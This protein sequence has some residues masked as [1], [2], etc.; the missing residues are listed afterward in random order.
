MNSSNPLRN[1]PRK[2]VVIFLLAV[3]FT[4]VAMGI[5]NDIVAMGRMPTLR[6]GLALMLSGA[7]AV[8]DAVAGVT[9]RSRI[10]KAF[11]PLFATQIAIMSFLANKYP[12]TPQLRQMDATETSRL[13][14]RLNFAGV[15]TIITVCL[16]YA[17]FVHVFVSESRR[18]IKAT[19][20]KAV[21]EA[22]MAA[23]REIQQVIVPERGEAF[24]GYVVDSVYQPARQV[25]GDF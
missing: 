13:E 9:L 4:F 2:A 20:E 10:W 11:F 1:A 16:G 21:L 3:F 14:R 23:A 17:G 5:A 24:P 19:A 22:E 7:F 18:H 12:N 25:G 6:F 8:C 15:A